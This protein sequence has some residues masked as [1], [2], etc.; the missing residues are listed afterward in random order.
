[1]RRILL[2]L[3]FS[4]VLLPAPLIEV[5]TSKPKDVVSYLRRSF[6]NTSL[7]IVIYKNYTHSYLSING[8]FFGKP[9]W[10]AKFKNYLKESVKN[11][12]KEEKSTKIQLDS[13]SIDEKGGELIFTFS[14]CN[15]SNEPLRG[16]WVA[17]IVDKDGFLLH[18]VEGKVELPAGA[19]GR[20]ITFKLRDKYKR[21]KI[22]FIVAIS[23]EKGRYKCS[24]S[25]V[26][27]E[28]KNR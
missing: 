2:C 16:K 20:P 7:N 15:Y 19:C 13:L 11:A 3:L 24:K 9:K 27:M 17:F 5:A 1:M 4:T 21:E 22:D 23:D 25:T 14:P 10:D 18:K 8:K 12:L 6:P 26:E 28:V